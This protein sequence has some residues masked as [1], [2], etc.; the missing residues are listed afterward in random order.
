MLQSRTANPL[1]PTSITGRPVD[2]FWVWVG[3]ILVVAA[4]IDS[5][6]PFAGDVP[7][8]VGGSVEVV[9]LISRCL[10][11]VAAPGVGPW[12]SHA[13]EDRGWN[14]ELRGTAGQK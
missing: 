12:S 1:D 5:V 13:A 6:Q 10:Q 11:V 3:G 14:G 9:L 8:Y 2:E 4:R 7:T